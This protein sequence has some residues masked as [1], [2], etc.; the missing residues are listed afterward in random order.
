MIKEVIHKQALYYKE[1]LFLSHKRIPFWK[2]EGYNRLL[3]LNLGGRRSLNFGEFLNISKV[4][5]YY[6]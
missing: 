4:P 1:H 3:D 2:S 5:F 6:F